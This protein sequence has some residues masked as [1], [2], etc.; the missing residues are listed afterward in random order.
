MMSRVSTTK[1]SLVTYL[2]AGKAIATVGTM[3]F[4]SQVVLQIGLFGDRCPNVQVN[5]SAL[6]F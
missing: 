5:K 4:E 6:S 2:E 3:Q 1:T